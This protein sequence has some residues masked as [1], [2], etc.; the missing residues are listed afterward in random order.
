MVHSFWRCVPPVPIGLLLLCAFFRGDGFAAPYPTS[1]HPQLVRTFYTSQNG[2]ADNQIQAVGVAR[3]GKTFASAGGWLHQLNQERWIRETGPE[4]VTTLFASK[5]G[6][7]LMAAGTN[8]L[9]NLTD[10]GWSR[11][12]NAPAAIIAMAAE[13]DGTVWILAKGGVW[14]WE[15]QWQRVHELDE[16]IVEPRSLLP[17]GPDDAL[18]ASRSGL[19]GLMGKRKYWL[20]LEV[21]PG[22]LISGDTRALAWLD[23]NHILVATDQGLNISN[24]KDGW[25]ALTGASGL[26]ILDLTG[27]AVSPKRAV[28]LASNDGLIRWDG[29]EWTLLTGKRWV[30]DDRITALAAGP[31]EDV[32]VGTTNGLAHLEYRSM[33]LE[34]KAAVY[35]S[36]LEARDRRHGYVTQ[37]YL[38]APGVVE[39]AVQEVSDNDGLWT[40]LYIASQSFRYAATKSSEAKAQA[41]RSMQAM[42]RLESITGISGFPARAICHPDEPQFDRRS[43][44]SSPEW[45]PS[46]VEKDWYW[47]GETSSDELDGHY[48]GWYLFYELAADDAQKEKVRA[49]CKRVTDHLLDRG[50]YLV[51]LDGQPTTWGVW[52]PEKLNDDPMW[53]MERSLNSLEILSH[54]KVA[55]HLVGDSRY[56]EAY[57]DLVRKHHYALNTL[58]AKMPGGVSHDDQLFFLAYYPLLQ[59][60]KDPGLRALFAASLHRTWTLERVEANPLWNFIYGAST[61][62][63]CDVEQAVRTLRDFPLD[64][65]LWRTRHS[66][67][68]DLVYDPELLAQ[69]VQ[70][71]ANPLSMTERVIHKWDKSPFDLD[72]GDDRTEGDPTTW[73]LPYWMGKYHQLID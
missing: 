23:E 3:N 43:L 55:I 58:Q 5:S 17:R 35:Q 13:P 71:L 26:P 41:W 46:P 67:R 42:L 6:P 12:P 65:I 22:G 64:F 52:A 54:L 62:R 44:R 33:S 72:D 7:L 56:E 38:K 40:A 8:G 21:R 66:Q 51:D 19:Y 4:G 18:L 9:W 29:G 49:T 39:G 45:H 16:D 28:W 30:P 50:F 20:S 27:L 1:K 2:L 14:R 61:G 59:L 48:F 15:D 57:L 69:G 47:K 34:E 25:Q 32:W 36:M 31:Q 68:A 63:S 73:L 70:R 10:Q 60:E 53:W 11:D 37:M 24:G